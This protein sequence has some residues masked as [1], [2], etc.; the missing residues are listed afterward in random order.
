MELFLDSLTISRAVFLLFIIV[1]SVYFIVENKRVEPFTAPAAASAK[2]SESTGSSSNTAS[3][4]REEDDMAGEEAGDAVQ[5]VVNVTKTPSS[6]TLYTPQY[7]DRSN[8][9]VIRSV[10]RSIFMDLYQTPPTPE[11]LGFYSE[12]VKGRDVTEPVLKDVISSSAPVLK[13]TFTDRRTTEKDLLVGN[14]TD[15]IEIFNEVLDRNPDRNELYSFAQM[16]AS[17]PSFSLDKLRQVLIASEEF[18]RLE[19]T[20][21]NKVYMNLQSNV[22]DRQLTMTVTKVWTDVT[23]RTYIDEDTLKFLKKKFV[24]FELN[25]QKLA[26]FIKMYLLDKPYV[27]PAPKTPV[28][29]TT[30]SSS[31]SS[32]G[33]SEEDMKKLRDSIMAELAAK[34]KADASSNTNTNAKE[35]Q[36]NANKNA[37][38]FTPDGKNVFTDNVF[39]FYGEN[40]PNRTVIDSLIDKSS[41]STG[42]CVNTEKMISSIKDN[43]KC[44]FDKNA[45]EEE[46]LEQHK[47]ELANYI[48]DRNMSHLG[49]V[50][51]RNKKF[52]KYLNADDN[53]VL[54]P[55]FKWS[56]PMRV[57]PV[58]M[59]GGNNPSPLNDQTALIGTLLEDAHDTNVGSILPVYPPV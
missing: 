51:E 21:S 39:N 43:A 16:L 33:M 29:S 19:R 28:A 34:A 9:E 7:I 13:K 27:E 30:A 36:H 2:T 57:P 35:K 26:E 45:A 17:D 24:T 55:E 31:K 6:N 59:G 12:Y 42:G 54:Y 18:K 5:D 58:C 11:E 50:C 4:P 48:N 8:M 49:T 47:Q 14:E 20:Q 52:G 15:I 41:N 22:T 38:G 10:I 44:V 56:V 3:Q 23:K 37:E 46:L 32:S 1:V 53:M 40:G 25:E